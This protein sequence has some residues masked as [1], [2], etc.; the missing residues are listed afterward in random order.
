M[1]FSKLEAEY[2]GKPRCPYP[3]LQQTGVRVIQGTITEDCG[4]YGWAERG[5]VSKV[6]VGQVFVFSTDK[7]GN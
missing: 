4:D 6:R 5:P 7:A 3:Q 2:F 1:S